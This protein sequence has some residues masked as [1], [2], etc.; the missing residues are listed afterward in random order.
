MR[1]Y[2]IDEMF[3]NKFVAVTLPTKKQIFA[4]TGQRAVNPSGMYTG[5]DAVHFKD[6]PTSGIERGLRAIEEMPE[7]DES[8]K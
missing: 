4:R 6:T 8:K 7:K 5:D 3:T 2:P 1:Y